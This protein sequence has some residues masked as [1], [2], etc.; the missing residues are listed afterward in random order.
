MMQQ[1]SFDP[2]HKH[3]YF[4]LMEI[5]NN[6]VWFHK[7]RIRTRWWLYWEGGDDTWSLSL[8]GTCLSLSVCQTRSS[9]VMILGRVTQTIHSFLQD[10]N[11]KCGFH[12]FL[13][14][15]SH[16]LIKLS[17]KTDRFSLSID[18]F[19]FCSP[20]LRIISLTCR[21]KRLFA[22]ESSKW[23]PQIRLVCLHVSFQHGP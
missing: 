22:R 18:I 23:K 12:W 4:I 13:L 6:P 17:A 14:P 16:F 11:T 9:L 15:K 3:D 5:W 7:C 1:S 19:S 21:I 20:I 8:L 2:I 10:L